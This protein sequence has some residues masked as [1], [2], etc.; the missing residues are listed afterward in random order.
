MRNSE[1]NGTNRTRMDE[2]DNFAIQDRALE[3]YE[4]SKEATNQAIERSVELAKKYPVH[5]ALGAGAVGLVAGVI[6]GK[7]TK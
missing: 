1:I 3:A 7:I 5:S 2:S 4:N 6:L